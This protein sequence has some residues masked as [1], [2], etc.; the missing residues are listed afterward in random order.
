MA[1][2]RDEHADVRHELEV[3][4]ADLRASVD[5]LRELTEEL[6]RERLEELRRENDQ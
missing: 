3:V 6:R 4:L 1:P 5:D 2:A